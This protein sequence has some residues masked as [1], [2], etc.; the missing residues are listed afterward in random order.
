MKRIVALIAVFA[1]AF[2]SGASAQDQPQPDLS[3][4]Y[5]HS[6][7]SGDDISYGVLML[8]RQDDGTYKARAATFGSAARGVG[9]RKGDV[10]SVSWVQPTENGVGVWLTVYAIKGKSLDGEWIAIGPG[11]ASRTEK[12]RWV[13]KLKMPET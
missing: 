13:A 1:F 4:I 3:G 8:E 2:L 11:K 12:A 10:L 5:H 9:I 6:T 7:E